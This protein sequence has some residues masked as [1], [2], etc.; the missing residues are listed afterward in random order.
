MAAAPDIEKNITRVQLFD[1]PEELFLLSEP[2]VIRREGMD[3]TGHK[4]KDFDPGFDREF[5]QRDLELEK[6][7]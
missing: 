6:L 3:I 7:I 2:D 5:L 1:M 4:R